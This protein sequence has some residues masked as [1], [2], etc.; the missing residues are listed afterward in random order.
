MKIQLG[1]LIALLAHDAFP[2]SSFINLDFE[3]ASLVPSVE[4]SFGYGLDSTAA[5]PGWSVLVNAGPM[6]WVLSNTL[7]LTPYASAT[8][9]S[10]PGPLL[11]GQYSVQLVSGLQYQ[12]TGSNVW[13]STTLAQTGLVPEGSRSLRLTVAN[14]PFSVSLGGTS[15]SLVPLS[16]GTNNFIP[17]TV[18]GADISGH[19]NL[20]EELRITVPYDA[21]VPFGQYH[22]IRLDDISFS[23]NPIPE[24]STWSFIFLGAVAWLVAK[25]WRR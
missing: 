11:S 22:S 3:S 17:Y 9:W 14:D 10:V 5:L 19:A 20:S 8:L 4:P 16:Y 12:F 18:W 23:P 15:L 6:S 1:I 21:G 7:T 13:T 24:P 2:Q 25:G